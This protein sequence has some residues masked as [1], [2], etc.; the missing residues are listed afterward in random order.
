MA[1]QA[2]GKIIVAGAFPIGLRFGLARYNIDGS[3]DLTFGRGGIVA[4]DFSSLDHFECFS[5][6][7]V[8]I[9]ADGKIVAAG[10]GNLGWICAPNFAIARYNNDAPVTN[11]YP[12]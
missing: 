3:L 12:E 10:M 1:I 6:S 4:T 11:S 8:A 2:D 5:A 7:S 9:Q